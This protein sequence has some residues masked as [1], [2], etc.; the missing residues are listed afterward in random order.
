MRNLV[1]N[2]VCFL[3]GEWESEKKSFTFICDK[4]TGRLTARYVNQEVILSCNFL[5]VTSKSLKV[6]YIKFFYG[7][8]WAWTLRESWWWTPKWGVIVT[9][10]WWSDPKCV[11]AA[12]PIK[13]GDGRKRRRRVGV[14]PQLCKA[15][16]R[17]IFSSKVRRRCH[18]ILT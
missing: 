11:S 6:I 17:N 7:E 15:P 10:V 12:K 16:S 14:T 8:L 1:V 13:C 2:F 18:N 5:L 3:S 4:M 9:P